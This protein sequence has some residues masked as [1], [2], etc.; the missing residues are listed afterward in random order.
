MSATSSHM[1]NR[2]HAADEVYRA[3][4]LMAS[5]LSSHASDICLLFRGVHPTDCNEQKMPCTHSV[6]MDRRW[7]EQVKVL[8]R[9]FNS[10]LATL[11]Q[12][13]G[14]PDCDTELFIHFMQHVAHLQ[15]Y[16][17]LLC[18]WTV[19]VRMIYSALVMMVHGKCISLHLKMDKLEMCSLFQSLETV[20]FKS[21]FSSWKQTLNKSLCQ[22]SANYLS[23]DTKLIVQHD[24]RRTG[25]DTLLFKELYKLVVNNGDKRLAIQFLSML[26]EMMGARD[27]CA[28][29][30]SLSMH[31]HRFLIE[32]IK[33][34]E[35]AAT[36]KFLR[37]H[38]AAAGQC[39]C[40][41]KCSI[42]G[43][44]DDIQVLAMCQTCRNTPVFRQAREPRCRRTI[45]S[46]GFLNV[47]TVDG[48]TS[49]IH[50]P[51]YRACVN[52]ENGQLIYEHWAYTLS[53]DYIGT[54]SVKA[55]IYMLCVGGKRTCTTVFLTDSLAKTKCEKCRQS[56]I[57][58][59]TCLTE[60]VGNRL[61]ALCDGCI[62]AACCPLHAPLRLETKEVWLSILEHF[63]RD[64]S[65][66]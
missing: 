32:V 27:M 55:S 21:H 33:R 7:S 65:V 1:H 53:T 49:F 40:H 42:Y 51:L 48:N 23:S 5:L 34:T 8:F 2:C 62:I 54:D 39:T 58:E 20:D 29:A 44:V 38:F 46:T 47:C 6:D 63:A 17:A 4:I 11:L 56:T 26:P 15:R 50:V 28:L 25:L 60:K 35:E 24:E 9:K 37:L 64:M 14:V 41:A 18:L 57:G 45:S 10:K 13:P 66:N 52:K 22:M 59:R 12:C 31:M 19:P 43:K 36:R 3:Q 30:Q 61:A 16:S